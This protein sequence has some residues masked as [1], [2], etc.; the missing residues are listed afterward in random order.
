LAKFRTANARMLGLGAEQS[1]TK[2]LMAILAKFS[3]A[4]L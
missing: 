3:L 2:V 4:E 1:L